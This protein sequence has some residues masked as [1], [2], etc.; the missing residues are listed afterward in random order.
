ML[1][2]PP[3]Q[4][5][6]P[7][8]HPPQAAL[9]PIDC[10]PVDDG[11]LAKRGLRRLR[12][13][14]CRTDRPMLFHPAGPIRL[15]ICVRCGHLAPAAAHVPT[16]RVPKTLGFR[17]KMGLTPGSG[18]VPSDTGVSRVLPPYLPTPEGRWRT[19]PKGDRF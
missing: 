17:R 11:D 10:M 5:R 14:H 2:R 13:D 6:K 9:L 7:G 16:V 18:G 8:K 12:C 3:N 15:W 4:Q 19:P 1:R